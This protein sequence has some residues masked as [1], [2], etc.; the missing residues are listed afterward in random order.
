MMLHY[1]ITRNKGAAMLTGD[2]GFGKTTVSRKLLELLDPVM[3]R[4][5]MIVDPML[6]ASQMLQEILM[7]LGID[8]K[9]RNRQALLHTLHEHLVR[10]YERG[11]RVVLIVDEAHLIRSA[12]TFEE[13][14][15]LLNCQM[16]DQFLISLLL[17]GQL[18]LRPKVDKVP[19][20]QQRLAVRYELKPLDQQETAEMIQHRL[21]TAGYANEYGPFTP[22]AVYELH[23]YSNGTPRLISQMADNALMVG[24]AQGLQQIDGATMHAI[25]EDYYEEGVAA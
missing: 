24:M 12:A 16:N 2:I 17:M 20:L 9:S 8:S 3:F 18:E 6:S 25:I 23:K 1:A 22:E 4:V 10:S 19:A 14:R 7:Q 13:L 15:L 5:V 11:Q 21:R